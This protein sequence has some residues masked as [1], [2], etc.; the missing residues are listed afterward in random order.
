MRMVTALLVA[1][2]V[3]AGTGGE[4]AATRA[5][6]EFDEVK[7]FR[8]RALLRALGRAFQSKWMWIGLAQMTLAFFSLLVLLSRED[9]SFAVPATALSYAVGPLGAKFLL[10]EQVS[11]MRWAGVLLVCGGVALVWAG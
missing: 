2:V 11:R 6:R 5:M 7:E 9:V 1:I 8:P 10:G 3:L 4:I